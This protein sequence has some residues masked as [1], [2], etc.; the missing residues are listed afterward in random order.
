MEGAGM[1]SWSSEEEKKM[2]DTYWEFLEFM[3]G[4]KV[5][6][7]ICSAF[8]IL[9]SAQA[10]GKGGEGLDTGTGSLTHPSFENFS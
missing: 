5:L 2:E 9:K 8:L 10:P 1:D 7:Q 6:W 4:R 3:N